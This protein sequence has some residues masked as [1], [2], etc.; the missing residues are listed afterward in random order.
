MY[1]MKTKPFQGLSHCPLSVTWRDRAP[2]P[3]RIIIQQLVCL[4]RCWPSATCRQVVK[5]KAGVAIKSPHSTIHDCHKQ[6]ITMARRVQMYSIMFRRPVDGLLYCNCSA[7]SLL[8]ANRLVIDF[9]GRKN[10]DYYLMISPYVDKHYY[11]RL[12]D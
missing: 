10:S 3:E 7:Q 9:P 8:C 12:M 5:R 1:R 11:Y 6:I 4:F 2:S